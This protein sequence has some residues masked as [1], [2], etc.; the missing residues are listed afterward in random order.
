MANSLLPVVNT[1]VRT[2]APVVLALQDRGAL[3]G[4]RGPAPRANPWKP[5]MCAGRDGDPLGLIPAAG[6]PDL[7]AAGHAPGKGRNS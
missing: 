2:V 7:P 5:H 4:L 1:A 6:G 3:R